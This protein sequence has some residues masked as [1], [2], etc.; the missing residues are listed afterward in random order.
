MI[1]S[2]NSQFQLNGLK[3]SVNNQEG[4]GR[5]DAKHCEK[6]EE[7]E[8]GEKFEKKECLHHL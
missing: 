3:N 8:M 2:L 7:E 5:E 4:R 6:K 1:F